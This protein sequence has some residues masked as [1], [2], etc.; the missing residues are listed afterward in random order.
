[1]IAYLLFNKILQLSVFMLFGFIMVKLKLV[2]GSDSTVLSKLCLYLLMPAAL[3][4]SFDVELTPEV[5]VGIALAFGAAIFLHFLLL[6]VDFGYKKIFNGTSVERTS[7]IYSNA[8][9]LIIPI[10]T[11]VLGGE[12]VIYSCAF[13]SVQIVFLWT[14]AI[15]LFSSDSKLNLKKIFLN[16]NIIAVII[17]VI[18]LVSGFRLPPFAKDITSSLSGM[19]GVVAM[20]VAGMLAATMD[21]KSVLKN[22]R[23]YLVL[24]MRLVVCPFI[25]LGV[26]KT[27]LMFISIPDAKNILLISY[28]ACITPPAATITQ[29]AQINNK[30][31]DFAVAINIVA[32]ILCI[33]TM[34]LFVALFQI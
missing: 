26:L 20:L 22:K 19:L 7:V 11:Y 21:F 4:N 1:M 10:V 23:L 14:H 3:I 17:G 34:P 28:M 27:A 30:D 24:F 29:F 13:M 18:M 25:V 15:R 33:A 5:A 31:A 2:K 9:N 8:A 12:W 16:S 32:T 6:G